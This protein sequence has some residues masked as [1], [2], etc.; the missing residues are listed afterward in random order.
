MS[1][2]FKIALLLG[3]TGYCKFLSPTRRIVAVK[4]EAT[5]G[6]DVCGDGV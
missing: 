6:L 5:V 1:S 2:V 4:V 3:Q